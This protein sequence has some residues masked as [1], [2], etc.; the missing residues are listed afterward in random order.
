VHLA[1]SGTHPAKMLPAMAAR[2][3]ATYGNPGDLVIDP[4]CGR[5]TICFKVL[6]YIGDS[7]RPSIHRPDAVPYCGPTSVDI[8]PCDE[9]NTGDDEGDGPRDENGAR[10]HW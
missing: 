10:G 5:P 4:M 9:G 8:A 6:D 1:D 2:A 3:I 7:P